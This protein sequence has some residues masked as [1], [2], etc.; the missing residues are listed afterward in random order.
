MVKLQLSGDRQ[1]LK[2]LKDIGYCKDFQ[3]T[4]FASTGTS[5]DT[6]SQA[7]GRSKTFCEL[8]FVKAQNAELAR[9]LIAKSSQGISNML[10]L[11]DIHG[12]MATCWGCV[13]LNSLNIGHHVT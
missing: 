11:D 4:D 5:F 7:K 9:F 6:F 2:Y 10:T 12:I 3:V 8:M 1:L 13:Y